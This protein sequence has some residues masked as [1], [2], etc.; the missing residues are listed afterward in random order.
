MYTL[1]NPG[2]PYSVFDTAGIFRVLADSR[3]RLGFTSRERIPEVE[4]L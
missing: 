3:K 1:V 4:P 2:L